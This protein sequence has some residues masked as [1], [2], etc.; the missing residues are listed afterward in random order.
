MFCMIFAAIGPAPL[1]AVQD[2]GNYNITDPGASISNWTSGWPGTGIDGWSYVGQV[3]GA[4]GTYLGNGWVITAAHVGAG[5]FTLGGI[6]YSLLGG[7]ATPI[8][9]NAD[10]L[11]FQV[12]SPPALPPLVLAQL[13]PVAF[14]AGLTGDTVV[15]IGYGGG[16]GKAW[17]LNT[18]TGINLPLPL[19]GWSTTDF[20]AIYGTTTIGSQSVTNHAILVTGDSGGGDFIFDA[21]TSKWE[22]AGINEATGGASYFEQINAYVQQILDVTG[23]P[24]PPVITQMPHGTSIILGSPISLPV[25]ANGSSPLA[26]QW[27]KD[28][29]AISGATAATL[30]I[31]NASAGDSG[32]Y[33]VTVTNSYGTVSSP[34]VNATVAPLFLTSLPNPQPAVIGQP[35]QYFITADGPG[36]FTYQWQLD[37]TPISGATGSSYT[38]DDP[39]AG[40]T[41]NY[42]V[43]VSNVLGSVTSNQSQ[44][45]PVVSQQITD[46]GQSA[47][48]TANPSGEGP[49]TYQWQFNGENINS[50]TDQSYTVSNAQSNQS[51]IYTVVIES[52]DGSTSA[53]FSLIVPSAV[54]AMPPWGLATL[55]LLNLVVGSVRLI[56]A[57]RHQ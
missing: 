24:A 30:T 25:T 6:T 31:S 41:G 26:Y 3:N 5:N 39:T 2:N 8:G 37:G 22:L 47:T 12:A 49:F 34:V 11:L 46:I 23:I 42:S 50:A 45:V 10:M 53:S 7:T 9:S 14:A 28:G 35:L 29:S 43:E 15:I 44:L 56:E 38:V 1:Q 13:P 32:S 52:P 19:S 51:G 20:D 40:S 16:H 36:P 4:S 33:Y 27:Y 21:S 18:V 55:V 54:P 57:K 17:G 48:F